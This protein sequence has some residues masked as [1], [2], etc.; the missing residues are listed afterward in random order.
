MESMEAREAL[1]AV[2]ET[3]TRAAGGRQVSWVWIA[4]LSAAMGASVGLTLHRQLAGFLLIAGVCL[5]TLVLILV[6]ER[7]RLPAVRPALKQDVR[8][9]PDPSW[10]PTL[11]GLV[12]VPLLM[13]LPR[14][15][16]AVSVCT[17]I[18]V[19]AGMAWLLSREW[20]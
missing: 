20:R 7:R 9:D 16:V 17:G 12:A 10:I 4:L 11:P 2:R 1:E 5:L 13:F 14:D 8:P 19:T 3:E 18:A 15:N 6:V